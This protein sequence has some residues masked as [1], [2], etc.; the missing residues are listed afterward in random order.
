M[1]M[2]K[3]LNLTGADLSHANL[4]EATF[5]RAD[6][7]GVNAFRTS[8]SHA[9]LTL[10]LFVLLTSGKLPS[11]MRMATLLILAVPILL[12]P[13]F[14]RL[15]Y[16]RQTSLPLIYIMLNCQNAY[17]SEA[18]FK[19]ANL[20]QSILSAADLTKADLDGGAAFRC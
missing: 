14:T 15:T 8:F 9:I 5:S 13:G 18:T 10:P 1:F 20:A 19:Y 6:F 17:L 4:R 11:I 16:A 2:P 12:I 3:R 7:S